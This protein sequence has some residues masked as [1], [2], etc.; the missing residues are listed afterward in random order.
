MTSGLRAI[1]YP[2]PPVSPLS[3][4]LGVSKKEKPELATLRPAWAPIKPRPPQPEVLLVLQPQLEPPLCPSLHPLSR[5]G[6]RWE[7]WLNSGGWDH[8]PP[9]ENWDSAPH[10]DPPSKGLC[11]SHFLLLEYYSC[12]RHKAA[13]FSDKPLPPRDYPKA[14]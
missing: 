4:P 8:C 3:P 7:L 14:K 10:S 6:W 2:P 9:S 11:I 13:S 5:F 1:A 12:I